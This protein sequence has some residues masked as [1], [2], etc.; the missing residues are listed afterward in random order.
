MGSINSVQTNSSEDDL[1]QQAQALLQDGKAAAAESVINELLQNDNENTEGLYILAVCQRYLKQPEQALQTLVKLNSVKPEYG[2]AYQEAGHNHRL[3]R[4]T[5]SA[6]TAYHKAVHYNPALVASWQV[7]YELHQQQGNKH[8]AAEARKPLLRLQEMPDELV[9]V[10]S[11]LHEGKLYKAERLCRHFLQKTPHHVEAMRLLA[12]LGVKFMVLD[13]AE[14]LLESCVEFEPENH[15]ARFDYAN[16]LF[17]RYKFKQ[18]LQQAEILH[19]RNPTDLAV[20]MTLANSHMGAGD[21]DSALTIYHDVLTETPDNPN[22]LLQQAHALKTVGKLNDAIAS[23]HKA[24]TVKADYGD[25]FWSLANLK[26]YR[27]SDAE[28]TAMKTREQDDRTD[29]VDRFHFC[30]ALGKAFEDRKDFAVAMDYYQRGNALKKQQSHIRT[31]NI[32]KDFKSQISSCTSTLFDAKKGCGHPAPDPIFIVGLPRA[33]STLL[34][35]ILASHSQVDGTMELHNIPALVHRL[36]GRRRIDDD[37]RYPGILYELSAEQLNQYGEDFINST[38]IYRQGAP[39]FIDKMPNNFR[40][41]GLIHLILPNAKIIDA[42]RDP[43]ACCFSGFKQLFAEGQEFTYGLEEI[44]RHYKGY[45][46]LMDHWDKVIPRKILRVQHEDV[47][48]DLETEVRRMLD[49]CGL[50]Y[51]QACVEFY[52][53]DRAIKTPSSEQVRQPIYKSGLEQWRN[54]EPYLQPLKDA[55][56]PVLTR[57]PI[58]GID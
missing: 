33:G 51:E 58:P 36:K 32:E 13:D 47:V 23:Y 3:M 16:V 6:I 7:L 34:E 24:Y 53:T 9:S 30:F 57:Y 10:T 11:M 42:R 40:H 19:R 26:T 44:G 12:E 25:A 17:K 38:Q 49:F 1:A 8:A 20:N 2:R 50:P 45:V 22:V 52:K 46:E 31:E 28:I 5:V 43:M 55:L 14:F 15:H 21:M 37:P 29:F 18:A 27:F 56:G 54:F 39:F 35:Q 41:I 48:Q 4:A